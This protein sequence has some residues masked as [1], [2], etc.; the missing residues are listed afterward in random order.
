MTA[1]GITVSPG[2]GLELAFR[3]GRSEAVHSL[4]NPVRASFETPL[5][6]ARLGGGMGAGVPENVCVCCSASTVRWVEQIARTVCAGAL[7]TVSQ[8]EGFL[9]DRK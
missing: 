2:N 8:E 1:S 9:E 5:P 6:L 7:K 3:V 4:L